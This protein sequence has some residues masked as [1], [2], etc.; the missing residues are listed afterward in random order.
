[1]AITDNT[2]VLD[3]RRFGYLAYVYS[4]ERLELQ[5]LQTRAGFYVGTVRDD[6]PCSRESNEY[7]QSEEAAL[8]A[9]VNDT[10]TQKAAP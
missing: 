8:D 10:W 1:M 4:G 6:M 3:F 5:V 2:E 7:Y 9:L